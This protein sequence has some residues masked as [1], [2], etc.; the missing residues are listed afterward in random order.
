MKVVLCLIILFIIC[1]CA[2]VPISTKSLINKIPQE[3]SKNGNFNFTIADERD[4][5]FKNEKIIMQSHFPSATFLTGDKMFDVPLNKV[6]EEMFCKRFINNPEGTRMDIKLKAFYST[7][8]PHDLATIPFVG[9][10]TIGADVECHGI[11]K[12]EIAILN[13]E[14]KFIF[15]KVYDFNLKEMRSPAEDTKDHILVKTFNKF[16]DELTTD[17]SRVKLLTLS[18][19]IED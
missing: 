11:L 12:V 16:S 18:H 1:G 7:S 17:L 3:P 6:F 10:F 15:H 5:E 4:E 2:S 9:L 14:S 13:N 8:K 19:Y